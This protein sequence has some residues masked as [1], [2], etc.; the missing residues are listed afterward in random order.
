MTGESGTTEV[1]PNFSLA[2]Q[3]AIWQIIATMTILTPAEVETEDLRLR[4][5]GVFDQLGSDTLDHLES[6]GVYVSFENERVA[7][8]GEKLQFFYYVL[9]G[10]LD[11][12][13]LSEETGEHKTLATVFAGQCFGEM[14]FLLHSPATADV[15]ANEPVVTWTIPHGAL[16]SFTLVHPGGGQLVSNIAALLAQRLLQANLRLAR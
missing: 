7:C 10:H 4:S 6:L 12:T 16:R 5:T 11:V 8:E 1:T 9:Q 14:S 15:R 13:K 2:A 3:T